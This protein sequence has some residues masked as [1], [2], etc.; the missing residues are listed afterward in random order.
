MIAWLKAAVAVLASACLILS[1]L[2]YMSRNKNKIMQLQ[3]EKKEADEA[4][5]KAK[6]QAS[7]EEIEK[8]DAASDS[9]QEE[10]SREIDK[11]YVERRTAEL[12]S[13]GM[14]ARD[15]AAY[16]EAQQ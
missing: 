4:T 15:I 13:S 5:E 1:A 2:L 7:L 11:L 10:L 16:F 9:R 8:D 14:S 12:S 3:R 6:I